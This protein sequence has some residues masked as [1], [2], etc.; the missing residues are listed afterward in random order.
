M[1]QRNNKVLTR[2]NLYD[3]GMTI[4]K[5]LNRQLNVGFL[6]IE[7]VNLLYSQIL[8]LKIKMSCDIQLQFFFQ[9]AIFFIIINIKIQIALLNIN[10][11]FVT[12]L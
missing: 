11:N 6:K 5:L 7:V 4:E 2:P 10:T 3:K 12:Q 9:F 8:C 1:K